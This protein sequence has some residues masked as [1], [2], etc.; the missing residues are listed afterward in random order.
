M[1]EIQMPDRQQIRNEEVARVIPTFLRFRTIFLPLGA[2]LL[3]GIVVTEP[4]RWRL[5]ALGG[6]IALLGAIWIL[7]AVR[8]R[9]GKPYPFRNYPKEVGLA[10]LM[11]TVLIW[12][13]GS[14]ES[15]LLVIFVPMTMISGI[16]LGRS[17]ARILLLAVASCIVWLMA[18]SGLLGWL[19]RSLPGFLD[20]GTGF[21]NRPVYVLT[22]ASVLTGVLVVSS[23]IGVG[24]SATIERMLDQALGARQ[25]ALEG[26]AERNQELV[27]LSSALAH[28][29]KNPLAS[30]QGLVQLLAPG[31]GNPGRQAAR[32]EMLAREV[33]RMRQTLDELLNFSRPL[34][35]LTI[36]ELDPIAL[37]EE[38]S[39][40]HEGIARG[41]GINLL[42]PL[43]QVESFPCDARKVKQALVNLL[44]NALEAT[45]GGGTVRWVAHK[46]ARSL[47]L[48]VEDTGPGIDPSLIKRVTNPG[49]T[50]KSVG[51]GIGLTV[52]R[53]IAEQH[54]GTLLLENIEGG[55]CRALLSLTL[56]PDTLPPEDQP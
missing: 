16:A 49:V 27:F 32:H 52:A 55:G 3:T 34:G 10:L 22:M 12:M 29:L 39:L 1:D 19:P 31:R 5:G 28:E 4:T 7:D 24:I 15:P 13:T 23:R 40:L 53:T 20:A 30:I 50:T 41:Q 48:G 2:V 51:S 37:M 11:Q 8:L 9:R 17:R 54:G 44:Q 43:E 21:Y 36:I 25:Q 46:T 18:L 6:A 47:Q 56:P 33:D 14:M 45:P 42:P 35:D 26:L 38:L